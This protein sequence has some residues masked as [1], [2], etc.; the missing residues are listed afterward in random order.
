MGRESAGPALGGQSYV[1]KPFL[2]TKIDHLALL[3][4][5]CQLFFPF[6]YKLISSHEFVQPVYLLA[7]W[8]GLSVEPLLSLCARDFARERVLGIPECVWGGGE[9]A[10]SI[11]RGGRKALGRPDPAFLF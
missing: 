10:G 9:M 8:F 2:I 7:C 4:H 1:C 5:T 11:R 6:L 3:P